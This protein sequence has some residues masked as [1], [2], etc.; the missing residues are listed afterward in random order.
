MDEVQFPDPWFKVRHRKRRV[1]QPALATVL[2]ENLVPGGELW[3][4]SDVLDVA[5]EMR[6]V[7][8][9]MKGI[10]SK[11]WG[12]SICRARFTQ[13]IESIALG[14]ALQRFLL[15]LHW[16]YDRFRT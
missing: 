15:L 12:G 5:E 8:R 10:R 3:L 14:T 16:A 9:S 4:Q 11:F 2:A 1:M 6:A 13:H 7:V